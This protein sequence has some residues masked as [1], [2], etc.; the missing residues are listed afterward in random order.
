MSL[1]DFIYGSGGVPGDFD[2]GVTHL[3]CAII[4]IVLTVVLSIV[5]RKCGNKATKIIL[6]SVAGFQLFFELFWRVLYMCIGYDPNVLWPLYPCNLAGIL[7]PLAVLLNNKIMKKMFYLFGFIGGVLTFVMPQGIFCNQYLNFPILKSVLQHTALIL[8]PV[9]E[10]VAGT[11]RPKIKDF[12]WVFAGLLV[13]VFNSEV[14]SIIIGKTGD[15]MFFR[16]GLP[17]VIPGIPQFL[18][19]GVFG[20]L[21]IFLI[22]CA[23]D[24]HGTRNLFVKRKK[25]AATNE[26]TEKPAEIE[27]TPTPKQ[28]E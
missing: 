5:A 21:V 20:L 4:L 25:T 7:V 1:H 11:F 8:I 6:Y 27:N 28:N 17:F 16:S 26:T 14:M 9:I 13:H 19:L 15:Y 23:V 18:T 10:Y 2:Y 22:N 12:G 3:V 24:P